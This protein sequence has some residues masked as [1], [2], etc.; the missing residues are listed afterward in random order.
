MPSN[1]EEYDDL[2][3]ERMYQILATDPAEKMIQTYA[4]KMKSS[5]A[6]CL[7]SVQPYAA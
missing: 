5:S 7:A 1:D 4:E 6:L 3:E 2:K